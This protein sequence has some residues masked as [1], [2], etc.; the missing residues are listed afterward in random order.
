MIWYVRVEYADAVRGLPD[1]TQFQQLAMKLV[2]EKKAIMIPDDLEHGEMET[3]VSNYE[4]NKDFT[5]FVV[6]PSG[7]PAEQLALSLDF[8]QSMT[9]KTNVEYTSHESFIREMAGRIRKYDSPIILDDGNAVWIR[10]QRG[11]HQ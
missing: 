7:G 1:P 2:A 9:N 8:D 4:G 3:L 6:E 11:R 10:K 5:K